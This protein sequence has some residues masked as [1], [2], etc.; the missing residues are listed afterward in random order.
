MKP[1]IGSGICRMMGAVMELGIITF[2]DRK[3]L[4]FND[5]EQLAYTNCTG[6]NYLWGRIVSELSRS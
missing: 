5:H 1:E 6:K 3:A 2:A 4:L